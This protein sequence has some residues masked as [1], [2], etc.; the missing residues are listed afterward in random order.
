MSRR[1]RRTIT[2]TI[3]VPTTTLAM[4]QPKESK[5]KT[6]SPSPIS[7]L[8]TSGCT[9]IDGVSLIRSAE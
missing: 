5:P 4:R 1:A 9:T 2:S 8:P 7:H 6:F 3:S